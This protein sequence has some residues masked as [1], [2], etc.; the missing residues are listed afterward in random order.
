M[1][2]QLAPWSRPRAL[3]Y[4][5]PGRGRCASCAPGG[6]AHRLPTASPAPLHR[7][8]RGR[9]LQTRSEPRPP[10]L[11]RACR[12]AGFGESPLNGQPRLL[13]SARRPS[14]PGV[15]WPSPRCGTGYVTGGA[16]PGERRARLGP[17]P[18][19]LQRQVISGRWPC[20]SDLFA[21]ENPLSSRKPGRLAARRTRA[22]P[23]SLETRSILTRT[24]DAPRPGARPSAACPGA[25][26]GG[27]TQASLPGD[28]CPE[29]D[30]NRRGRRDGT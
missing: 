27:D 8:P 10:F 21:V 2:H 12:R 14:R 19:F 11:T 29:S 5:D 6:T 1:F 9:H 7:P 30:V 17:G 4:A 3:Q 23:G 22:P 16:A 18:G 15:N 28:A 26:R 20:P 13:F 24:V 25:G